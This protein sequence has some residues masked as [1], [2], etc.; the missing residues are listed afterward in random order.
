MA[1]GSALLML[2]L[3]GCFGRGRFCLGGGY[4]EEISFASSQYYI[5]D[6]RTASFF[7]FILFMCSTSIPCSK[8]ASL[9]NKVEIPSH[10]N[11]CVYEQVLRTLLPFSYKTTINNPRLRNLSALFDQ[12]FDI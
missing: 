4:R 9:G 1:F 7:F 3:W 5:G 6:F 8:E 10:P 2:G 11:D 12:T